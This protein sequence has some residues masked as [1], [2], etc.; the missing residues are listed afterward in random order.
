MSW[1]FSLSTHPAEHIG[2]DDLLYIA[3]PVTPP[4][5]RLVTAAY[6]AKRL[7]VSTRTVRKLLSS[8]ELPSQ[9]VGRARRIDPA[10]IERYLRKHATDEKAPCASSG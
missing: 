8:G 1:D 6:V 4:P 2:A 3:P 7:K 5:E 10:D 9:R